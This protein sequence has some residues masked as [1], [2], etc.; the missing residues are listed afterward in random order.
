MTKKI[1]LISSEV[2]IHLKENVYSIKPFSMDML[3]WRDVLIQNPVIY[4]YHATVRPATNAIEIALTKISGNWHLFV[5][6]DY[7]V[8][9]SNQG[10]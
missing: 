8:L 6:S 3:I 2:T 9:T 4:L 7:T 10:G 5:E 1:R